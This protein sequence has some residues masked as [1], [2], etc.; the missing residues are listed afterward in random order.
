MKIIANAILWRTN[1]HT[2]FT[3]NKPFTEGEA[4]ARVAVALAG[5]CVLGTHLGHHVVRS[6]RTRCSGS[7]SPDSESDFCMVDD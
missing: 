4:Y 5:L 3:Q 1:N 7:R 2:P 6:R